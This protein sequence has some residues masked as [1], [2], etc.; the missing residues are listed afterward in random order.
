MALS[1]ESGLGM[2]AMTTVRAEAGAV[3]VRVIRFIASVRHCRPASSSA[4]RAE[5]GP[6]SMDDA[7]VP[8][9]PKEATALATCACVKSAGLSPRSCPSAASLEATI[10]LAT[11]LGILPVAPHTS[12]Q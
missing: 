6:N 9:W 1:P 11:S 2:Q 7:P 4:R 5:T 10:A 12:A 8:S 3:A